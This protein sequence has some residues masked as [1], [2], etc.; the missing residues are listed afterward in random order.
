MVGIE[1]FIVFAMAALD[2]SVM[3]GS[4][5]LNT[6]VLYA[7]LFESDFKECLFVGTP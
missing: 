6:L 1:I 7:E 4:E 3:P 5:R 2:L